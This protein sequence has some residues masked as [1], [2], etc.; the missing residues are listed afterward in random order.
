MNPRA[1]SEQ[2]IHL[3]LDG[4]LPQDERPD[5]DAWLEANPEM[6][7]RWLR[8]E[9]DRAR[10]RGA[11]E[12]VT[13]E[14]MP[15]RLTAVLTSGAA[16]E[17][18]E[19]PAW[20]FVAIAAALLVVG[21]MGGYLLSTFTRPPAVLAEARPMVDSAIAAH[22]VYAN[23]KRHV[24]EV[25]AD[26]AEHLNSW[27]SNR[28]GV[29]LAAP[30]LTA[31]GLALVGGRLLPAGDAAAAQ[32]MYQDESGNRVSLYVTRG[33][34]HSDGGFRVAEARGEIALYWMDEGY[35]CV[36]TGKLPREQLT[37]IA[38]AA[39]DQIERVAAAR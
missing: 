38:D 26:E 5:F 12:G 15:T 9:E 7:A 29:R 11:L 25:G 8:Y 22:V 31:H 6:K 20:K 34:G 14:P 10:L 4:E 30:D 19:A 33:A 13:E 39:Y 24:V 3:A 2:D 35:G 18:A 1:F 37:R 21:G 27:L 36:V 32:Y 28:V 17:R 23:E 16:A